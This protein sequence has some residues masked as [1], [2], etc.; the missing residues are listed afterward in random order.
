M[1]NTITYCQWTEQAKSVFYHAEKNKYQN[2]CVLHDEK[3][4]FFHLNCK[5]WRTKNNN[6]IL[7]NKCYI[8]KKDQIFCATSTIMHT[9]IILPT[10]EWRYVTHITIQ[11]N[12]NNDSP[13]FVTVTVHFELTYYYYAILQWRFW[14]KTHKLHHILS[15]F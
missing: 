8:T 5:M 7:Q 11:W 4:S 3:Q 15:H 9:H 13:W 14:P 6:C 12:L 2:L 1:G 10:G